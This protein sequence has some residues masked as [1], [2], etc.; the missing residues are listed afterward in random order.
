MT[1]VK[2]VG[3]RIARTL[4]ATG[5]FWFSFLAPVMAADVP[6][7]IGEGKEAAKPAN[8]PDNLLTVI[9]NVVNWVLFI[10]GFAAV[11]MLIIGGVRYVVSA[12]SEDAVGK[13]KSTILYAIIGLVIAILAYAAVNFIFDA[14]TEEPSAML[15]TFVG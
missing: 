7:Q 4:G 5:A 10:V 14:L 11:V 2:Q 1:K 15:R 6:T 8:A 12:G 13:A 3:K 9:K